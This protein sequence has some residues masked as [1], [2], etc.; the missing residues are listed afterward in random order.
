MRAK[1]MVAG[2]SLMGMGV[3]LTFLMTGCGS[4]E[5]ASYDTPGSPKSRFIETGEANRINPDYETYYV[6]GSDG[7]LYLEERYTGY[8]GRLYKEDRNGNVAPHGFVYN[9]SDRLVPMDR[10]LTETD[11]IINHR[12]RD[13]INSRSNLTGESSNISLTTINGD[14]IV[15][16]WAPNHRTLSDLEDRVRDVAGPTNVRFE[17]EVQPS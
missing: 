2:L 10:F 17:M 16:G 11:R 12:I 7:R 1:Q 3:G 13:S 14:V 9:E 4:T 8:E 5:M 6:R 15:R